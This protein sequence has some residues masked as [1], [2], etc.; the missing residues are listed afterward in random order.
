SGEALIQ[1]L[2]Q[3]QP[4]NPDVLRRKAIFYFNKGFF[5]EFSGNPKLGL[6]FYEKSLSLQRKVG[7]QRDLGY[8]LFSVGSILADTFGEF[9]QALKYCQEAVTILELLGNR[10]DLAWAIAYLSSVYLSKGQYDTGWEYVEKSLAMIEKIGNQ[11]DIAWWYIAIGY[12][13]LQFGNFN[14]AIESFKK[15]IPI[16]EEINYLWDLA[17]AHNG[18]GNCYYQK[19]EFKQALDHYQKALSIRKERGDQRGIAS[20]LGKIGGIN[21]EMGDS[22]SALTN[23]KQ[24]LEIGQTIG[25]DDI[26]AEVLFQL[27]SRSSQHLTPETVT[28][29]LHELQILTK[30]QNTTVINQ[31]YQLAKALV[32]KTSE[33]LIDKVTAQSLFKNIV[34]GTIIKF[35]L[36]AIAM[37]Q[38]SQTLLYELEMTGAEA[39]L[40][41]LKHLLDRLL[42]IAKQQNSYW[43][44]AE[45]YLVQSKIALVEVDLKQAQE[46]LTQ[47]QQLADEKGMTK[48]ALVLSLEREILLDQLTNWEKFISRKPT[49]R[50]KIHFTRVEA[51]FERMTNR[52]LYH[53]EEKIRE[54]ALKAKKLIEQLDSN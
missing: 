49:I 9:E 23:F 22:N 25:S 29:Y 24:S 30:N 15:A 21:D 13:H 19:G 40:T 36:T 18:I 26:C 37:I 28:G 45:A 4:D 3:D 2:L 46:L 17:N 27:I 51:V 50:E 16:C 39:V 42:T 32:L 10:Q 35:E 11:R 7:T 38:L 1:K 6:K 54:Y 53:E 52:S 20:C 5:Y 8:S 31:R 41:E 34:D 47:A 33:R 43:L 48:L 14:L 44:M 12:F